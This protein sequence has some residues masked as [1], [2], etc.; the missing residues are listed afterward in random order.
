MKHIEMF[1]M[2]EIMMASEFAKMKMKNETSY[3]FVKGGSGNIYVDENDKI[4]VS[5]PCQ[6][7]NGYGNIIISK[8]YYSILWDHENNEPKTDIYISN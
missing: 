8:V 4:N 7:Q 6:S 5:F 2:G 3:S 1:L